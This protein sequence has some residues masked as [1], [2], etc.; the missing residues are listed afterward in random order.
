[1]Q[2]IHA[3]ADI[4]DHGGNGC[5]LHAHIHAQD[6]N[7]V[8]HNIDHCAD[9]IADHG[10]TR[11]AFRTDDVGQRIAENDKYR[12]CCNPARVA[13][14]KGERILR[15]A[16]CGQDWFGE[17][18]QHR[19]EHKTDCDR[20][21]GTKAGDLLCPCIPTR[22]QCIRNHRATAA[23]NQR[24]DGDHQRKHW[25]GQRNRCDHHIVMRLA[26]EKRIRHV[27]DDNDNHTDYRRHSHFDDQLPD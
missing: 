6:H 27:V 20:S 1:M 22:T 18:Q 13:G 11:S 9:Q 3:S 15:R 23:A 5:A 8:E 24:T 10:F 14:G 25:R 26:D 16:N 2:V 12:T 7:W 19:C 4:A 21:I 17:Q